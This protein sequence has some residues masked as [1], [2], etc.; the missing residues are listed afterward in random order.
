M[1]VCLLDTVNPFLPGL[2][3][4]MLSEFKSAVQLNQA[5]WVTKGGGYAPA[6]PG[7]GMI[8]GLAR[9]LRL[10]KNDM[11]LVTLAL[12]PSVT[13]IGRKVEHTIQVLYD[14]HHSCL[15]WHPRLMKEG[16]LKY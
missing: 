11:R 1:R 12:D 7:F 14:T 13:D 9:A 10:E 16:A 3:A 2:E 6:D 8:D 4:S 5:L 15:Q